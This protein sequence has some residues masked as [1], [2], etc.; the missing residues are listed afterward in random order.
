MK[1]YDCKTAPSPR[2]VRIFMAE[3]GIDIETVQVDLGSGEQF[4]ESYRAVNPDCVVPALE[5]DD[6]TCLSEVLAICTYLEAKYPEPPLL[7]TTDEERARI[8]MW[9]C[10]IEQQGLWSVADAF[11]NAAKGLK[12]K[13]TTGLVSYAQIPELAQRGRDRVEQFFHRIDGQLADSEFIAGDS[14]SI[15]DIAAMVVVDFSAWIKLTV[16]ED[17]VNTL[18]WHKAVSGRPSAVA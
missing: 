13:A 17:A 7:G 15:A 16:P 11:R 9:T 1:F 6:G 2:R 10:K 12:D 5:L 4:S 3:K 8:L 14:Y 18:R